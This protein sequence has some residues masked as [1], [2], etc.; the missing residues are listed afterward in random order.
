MSKYKEMIKF[1]LDF[2]KKCNFIKAYNNF[3]YLSIFLCV[4]FLYNTS[5]WQDIHLSCNLEYLEKSNFI[6]I[7]LIFYGLLLVV[8]NI[9]IGKLATAITAILAG[10]NLMFLQL[11]FSLLSNMYS[12]FTTVPVL[13]LKKTWL[14]SILYK[15]SVR[16]LKEYI[17]EEFPEYNSTIGNNHYKLLKSLS[18]DIYA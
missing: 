14:V 7:C 13:F 10:L 11:G 16:L 1:L 18:Y 5:K 17:I 8:N 15:P 4:L 2:S 6:F 9:N 3:V 12:I